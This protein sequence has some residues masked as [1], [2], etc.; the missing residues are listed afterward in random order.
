L[1]NIF[2]ICGKSS[3]GKDTVFKRLMDDEEFNIKRIVPYTTR[4]IRANEADGA[5]YHYVDDDELKR[6]E[7]EGRVIEKRTYDTVHGLWTYFTVDDGFLDDGSDR[8]MIGTPE[9]VM[10][11]RDYVSSDVNKDKN[12]NIVPIYITLDDGIRL[13][14]ALNRELVQDEPKYEE[15]CRRFLADAKDFSEENL[16]K[17]GIKTRFVN[18]DLNSALTDIKAFIKGIQNGHQ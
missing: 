4:P 3:S 8:I 9:A 16:E 13:Q 18:E 6:L 7:D 15:M 5:E 1:G 12:C 10:A 11:I 14:R 17:A 2:I